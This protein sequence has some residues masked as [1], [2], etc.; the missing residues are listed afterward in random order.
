VRI[1]KGKD[2][3]PQSRVFGW[4]FESKRWFSVVLLRFDGESRPAYHSHAF[5]SVSWLL[6]GRLTEKL[7]GGGSVV[8]TPSWK[9]I[10]TYKDTF[11]QVHSS[12]VSWVLTFRGP[13]VKT[14]W[15][16]D[17]RRKSYTKLEQGRNEV[18]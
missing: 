2:G 16:Y 17:E 12:G 9:P 7:L 13:W 5:N 14:W 8:Y 11:H 4:F 6:R 1:F 3:G 18:Y 10:M 15:E